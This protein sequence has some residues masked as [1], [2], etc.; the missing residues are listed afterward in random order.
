MNA[1]AAYLYDVAQRLGTA[2]VRAV[3]RDPSGQITS[4]TER[5]NPEPNAILAGVRRTVAALPSE[6]H[7]DELGGA[8]ILDASAAVCRE[9]A[10]IRQDEGIGTVGAALE[11]AR[12]T[13]V[14]GGIVPSSWYLGWTAAL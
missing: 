4:V 10:T 7:V 9:V 5:R 2:S 13:L 14:E 3:E 11:L 1:T 8:Q 6:L 12:D